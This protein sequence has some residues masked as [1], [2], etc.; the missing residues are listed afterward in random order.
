MTIPGL[1]AVLEDGYVVVKEDWYQLALRALSGENG[2][3]FCGS[4]REP[5]IQKESTAFHARRGC[6]D[7]GEW[8]DLVR[9]K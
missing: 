1:Q 6:L 2:C 9:S 3:P 7:C 5:Q 8:W 4:K